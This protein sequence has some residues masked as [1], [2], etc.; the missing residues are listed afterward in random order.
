MRKY[1][2]KEG[3]IAKWEGSSWAKKRAAVAKRKTLGDFE[4]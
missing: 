1:F 4:R 2:E 3:T